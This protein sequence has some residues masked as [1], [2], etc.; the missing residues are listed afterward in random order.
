MPLPRVTVR[1]LQALLAVYEEQSFSR[2]AEREHATQSGMSSQLKNLETTLG[3]PLIVRGR[4]E[5]T[6]TPTGQLAYAHG[7]DILRRLFELEERVAQMRGL[8]T[9]TIRLG[10]IPA[11]TRAVLP[12]AMELFHADYPG[13]EITVFEEYSFSLMRRVAEGEIDC[14]AV[15]AGDILPGLRASFLASDR[16]VL[17]ARAR[18]EPG[19]PHLAPVRPTDLSGLEFVLPSSINVRRKALETYF[20]AHGV[21]IGAVLEM[22]A[23]LGTIELVGTSDWCTILPTAICVPDLAGQVRTLHPIVDPPIHTNYVVVQ[24]AEKAPT[25]A[26]EGII[27]HFQTAAGAIR[28]EWD[29]AVSA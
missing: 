16:E 14:A 20:R 21:E 26:M 25:H 29:D 8:V 15:P 7:R 23:M 19:R 22:D 5:M 17:V 24:K 3:T 10:V 6:L 12:R 28:A 11:L 1:G 2:A 27:A 9:G 13:V 18:S 4:G